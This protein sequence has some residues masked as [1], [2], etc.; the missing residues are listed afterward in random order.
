MKGNT[1]GEVIC[2]RRKTEFAPLSSLFPLIESSLCFG[3]DWAVREAN[4]KSQKLLPFEKWK[5]NMEIHVNP[6]TVSER[7]KHKCLFCCSDQ[8]KRKK[9]G[10]AFLAYR[11]NLKNW[12]TNSYSNC[13]T[14]GTVGF[15]NFTVQYEFKR[16]RQ[17]NKQSKP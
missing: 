9:K 8:K 10:T 13:P 15:Y 5:N 6:C 12:D 2:R 3:R 14:N 1:P 11:K 7:S 16:C 4:R 17:N